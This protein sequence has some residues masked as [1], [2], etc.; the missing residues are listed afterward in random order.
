M[1]KHEIAVRTYEYVYNEHGH[2]VRVRIVRN[3]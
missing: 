2:L 1:K 3:P